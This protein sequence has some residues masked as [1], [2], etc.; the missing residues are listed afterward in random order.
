MRMMTLVVIGVLLILGSIVSVFQA[1]VWV[2]EYVVV[3]STDPFY[4]P[5]MSITTDFLRVIGWVGLLLGSFAVLLGIVGLFV[6]G[7]IKDAREK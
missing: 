6:S 1:T 7:L 4:H 5:E 2:S 3:P